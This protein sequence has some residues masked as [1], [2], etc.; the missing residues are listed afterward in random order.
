M[1]LNKI[2]EQQDME[3]EYYLLTLDDYEPKPIEIDDK[4]KLFA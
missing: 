3:V 4:W 1:N 2:A